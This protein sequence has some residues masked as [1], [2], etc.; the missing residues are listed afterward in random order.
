MIIVLQDLSFLECNCYIWDCWDV[1]KMSGR[2]F[3]YQAD[4]SIHQSIQHTKQYPNPRK[5][6]GPGQ[7]RQ[8]RDCRLLPIGRT[9]PRKS[10]GCRARTL[11]K[12]STLGCSVSS[13]GSS[14]NDA[15]DS[16]P[17]DSEMANGYNR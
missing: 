17:P 10:G 1:N 9:Q 3:S 12:C 4:H 16:F 7:T 2:I 11:E 6:I 13:T 14:S 15:L 5:T 8:R